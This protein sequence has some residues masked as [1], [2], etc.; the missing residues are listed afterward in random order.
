MLFRKRHQDAE[1]QRIAAARS[2]IERHAPDSG[3]LAVLDQIETDM[4]AARQDHTRLQATLADLDPDNATRALK[5]ALRARPSPLTPDTPHVMSL[6]QR[7]HTVHALRNRLDELSA[8]MERTLIDVDTLAAQSAAASVGVGAD[9]ALQEQLRLLT[10]DAANLEAAHR[11]IE[12][13]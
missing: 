8:D 2:S 4:A 13:L 9:A 1:S 10:A 12:S 5:D 11:E 7:H 6:R 3:A